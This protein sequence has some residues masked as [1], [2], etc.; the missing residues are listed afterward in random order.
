M[1]HSGEAQRQPLE[2]QGVR[3]GAYGSL[4]R[5][6]GDDLGRARAGMW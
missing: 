3:S 5:V 1:G 4:D 2:V 6:F